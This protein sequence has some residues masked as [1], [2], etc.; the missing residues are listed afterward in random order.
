MT[1]KQF[2]YVAAGVIGAA[3]IYYLPL[4]GGILAI[5]LK[6]LLIP[7][8]GASGPILAFVP[9]DGRPI[10][11]MAGN[12]MKA[13]FS[14]NQY[15][16]HKM[17]KKFS[18]STISLSKPHPSTSSGQDAHSTPKQK[19]INERG[20]E[21]QKIL[22]NSSESKIKNPQDAREAAFL[23]S[24]LA[25]PVATPQSQTLP[26]TP[27]G[28]PKNLPN[29]SP[30]P[31]DK[32]IANVPAVKPSPEILSE[33]EAALEKQLEFA[34]HQEATLQSP[35]ILPDAPLKAQDLEKQVAEI[36]SQKQLLEQEIMNLKKQLSTQQATPAVPAAKT[37]VAKTTPIETKTPHVR[38]VPT[39]MNKRLGI[40]AS[41]TPNVVSGM[42]KDARGNVLP[43]ILVEIK[44][45][46]GNPVRAFKTNSLGNFASAT[47]LAS[48]T[49]T[50]TLEDLKKQHT[51]DSIQITANDQI[52]QPIEITSYDKREELRKDL[53]S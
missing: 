7:L 6:I 15:I 37:D 34:T 38:S 1:V 32:P 52:M 10:D 25:S 4:P 9:V 47:P 23:S 36:H 35:S 18:F 5:F 26:A 24:I 43:N 40:F 45:K 21:L 14:P 20:R 51:F 3:I 2:G 29:A 53:F 42:V 16:Y 46:S 28:L 48:G 50:I 17:D 33:K 30:K 8:F 49:Y 19:M 39:D 27:P 31:S 22:I 12:F 13:L 11:I 41:D 44:D